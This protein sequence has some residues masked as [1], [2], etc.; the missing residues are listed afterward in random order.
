LNRWIA[1]A[2]LSQFAS[3]SQTCIVADGVGIAVFNV[4]GDIHAIEN[5]CPH[6][7]TPL[8]EGY[9][10]GTRSFALGMPPSSISPPAN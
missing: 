4:D 3:G 7:H 5:A 9:V 10:E 1:V 6:A 2:K 8:S